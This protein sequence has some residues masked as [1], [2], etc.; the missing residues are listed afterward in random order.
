MLSNRRTF[1]QSTAAIL[2]GTRVT[3][4]LAQAQ[5]RTIPD[6]SLRGVFSHVQDMLVSVDG[7]THRIAAGGNIRDRSNLI[8]VPSALPPGGA[9][10]D[11]ILDANGQ[12]LRV[13]LLTDTEARRVKNKPGAN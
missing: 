13:W 9:L 5:S 2:A 1:L 6:D 7:T 8:I 3:S 12:I 10:A 11:Y 4:C